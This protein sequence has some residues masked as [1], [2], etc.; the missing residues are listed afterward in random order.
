MA[1]II[2]LSQLNHK[3]SQLFPDRHHL[4]VVSE[5][6]HCLHV[7]LFLKLVAEFCGGWQRRDVAVK[8][9]FLSGHSG[10]KYFLGSER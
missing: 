10:T 3:L 1:S 9:A 8:V 6:L 5:L 4:I 7:L 2:E